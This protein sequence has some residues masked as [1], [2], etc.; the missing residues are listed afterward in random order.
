MISVLSARREGDAADETQALGTGERQNS[1]FAEYS[2]HSKFVRLK[3]LFFFFTVNSL[4]VNLR[5]CHPPLLMSNGRTH[6]SLSGVLFSFF[7]H[8]EKHNES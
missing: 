1:G 7:L 8:A 4:G 5:T 6:L 2:T 3:L